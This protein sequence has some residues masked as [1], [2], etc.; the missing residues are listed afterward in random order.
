[1]RSH[2]EAG[3]RPLVNELIWPMNNRFSAFQN[4]RMY[5]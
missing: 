2:A 3:L 4:D 5:N 1:M